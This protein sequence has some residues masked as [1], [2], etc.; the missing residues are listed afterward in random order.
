MT[1]IKNIFARIWAVWGIISFAAT[2]LI[3]FIPSMLTYLLPDPKGSVLFIKIARLWMN[4][5]L[6][7]VG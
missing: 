3:V 4:V 2:F 5:W 6:R 1:I 7:L